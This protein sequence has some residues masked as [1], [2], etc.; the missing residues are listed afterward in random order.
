MLFRSMGQNAPIQKEYWE[1]F[2]TSDWSNNPDVMPKYSIVE[3]CLDAEVDFESKEKMSA[4][5]LEKAASLA[6]E[7]Q[8]FLESSR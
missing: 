3:I 5:I 1:I 2:K 4:A 6:A 7:I 8:R